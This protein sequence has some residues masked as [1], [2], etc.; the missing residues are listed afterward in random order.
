MEYVHAALLLHEAGKDVNEENIKKVV[1][2]AGIEVNESKVKALIASLDGVDI[3]KVLEDAKSRPVA[4]AP[5]AHHAEAKVE[6]KK[7]K[8]EEKKEEAAEGLSAL[9]A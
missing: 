3:G 5:V 9:F 4:V 2:A 8:E 6:S 7:E 1:R